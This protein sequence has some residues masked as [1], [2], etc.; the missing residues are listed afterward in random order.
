M[1]D[2]SLD[3]L[4][5]RAAFREGLDPVALID[6]VYDRID[7]SGDP[8]IFISL[9]PRH[10]ARKAAAAL[11]GREKGPLWSIPF[12]VK[13][14]I[15]VAGLET[16]AACPTF[17]YRPAAHAPA[18]ERLIAAGAIVIGKTNL[19][20]FATGLVGVR[21][22]YPAPK[23]P[24][25]P[26]IIPGGSSSGSAVAVSRGL[27]SFALGTDT[28][29]SG[30]IPAGLNNIVGLKP[31]LGA[32]SGRGMV[33]ACRT[34]DTISIFA[35]T[36]DDAWNVFEV[37]AGEDRDDPYSR[38][39]ALSPVGAMP[40]RL[41]LGVPREEDLDFFGDRAAERAWRA[42]LE[43]AQSAG[44]SFVPVDMR[45]FRAVARLLYEGPWVAERHAATRQFLATNPDAMLPVTRG[46]IEGAL[47]FS[48]TDAFAA[49]YEL[50]RL[51]RETDA[52]L[53]SLDALFVPTLPLVPKVSDLIA[54]PLTPNARL[55]SFTNFVNLLDLAALAIPSPMRDDHLP[56]GAT[57]IARRGSDAMLASIGRTLHHKADVTMGAT[58]VRLPPLAPPSPQTDDRI[59]LVVVGAHL[60][61]MAL[62]HELTSRG[63]AF[64]REAK[65]EASYKLY[66]L[67]GGPPR[68]PG[69]L[70]TT[71]GAGAEIAVEIWALA[72]DAFGRFV[73]SIPAP[74]SIGTIKLADGSAAKGFLVEAE[75]IVDAENISHFGGWRAYVAHS[76]STIETL[77]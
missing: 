74:L 20:Q 64:R 60:S 47:K 59:E 15:D 9:V 72:P 14:N 13:D 65:T 38:P 57:L 24:F 35:L 66:A 31:S 25:D 45:P 19:D 56:A 36:V 22:P 69:L 41:R 54:D 34:L 63:A 46:I 61:G 55:G 75:G 44:A 5:L 1:A 76:T 68:R 48:A 49:I 26:A 77:S 71:K 67:A 52:A 17:A 33:P 32:I 62:N 28:A 29:G 39:F 21:T 27:V 6:A 2:L 37:A 4:S 18:V 12:A 42:A 43:I 23:N 40:P 58:G 7:A 70:R 73:A 10:E 3:L 11:G 53:A 50:A 51:K 16:T 8:G 30:R